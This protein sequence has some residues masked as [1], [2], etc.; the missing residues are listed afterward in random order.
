MGVG[1]SPLY[2][3]NTDA[4][5]R[6]EIILH[7]DGNFY[8]RDVR[9]LII[10]DVSSAIKESITDSNYEHST[11]PAGYVSVE[12]QIDDYK[13]TLNH[14]YTYTVNTGMS[15]NIKMIHVFVKLIDGFPFPKANLVKNDTASRISTEEC[16][17]ITPAT[18]EQLHKKAFYCN[19][20]Y[21]MYVCIKDLSLRANN[22]PHIRNTQR[23][24]VAYLF[25][26]HKKTNQVVTFNLPNI[27]DDGRICTGVDFCDPSDKVYKAHELHDY[28]SRLVKCL[29]DAPF[30]NDLRR[31][32][33]DCHHLIVNKDGFC[34]PS[35]LRE[36]YKNAV[37]TERISKATYNSFFHPITNELILDFAKCLQSTQH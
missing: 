4:P 5:I 21:D 31:E 33:I 12:H 22:N 20:D 6:S 30:N 15:H 16:Y 32:D 10:Q 26:V 23:V 27:F 14:P 24:P 9:E 19:H 34:M 17:N 2:I 18:S 29:Q 36:A 28:V 1:A 25:G 11:L 7:E 13:T 8:R 35:S 37:I 3:M